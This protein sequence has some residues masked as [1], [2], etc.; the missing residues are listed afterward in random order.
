MDAA[1]A[2][3]NTVCN[4]F[5]NPKPEQVLD[6]ICT[7]FWLAMLDWQDDGVKIGVKDNKVN[8]YP[9][10]E[11]QANKRR[12]DGVGRGDI[13]YLLPALEKVRKFWG[14][15]KNSHI[16][17]VASK[18]NRMLDRLKYPYTPDKTIISCVGNYRRILQDVLDGKGGQPLTE[19]EKLKKQLCEGTLAEARGLLDKRRMKSL[20]TLIDENQDIYLAYLFQQAQPSR[21][22]SSYPS[23]S[24]PRV[25]PMAPPAA[26]SST[27]S[28]NSSSPQ[29]SVSS[30][31]A[32]SDIANQLHP[33]TSPPRTDRVWAQHDA[34]GNVVG[35]H[36][37]PPGDDA[38]F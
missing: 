11:D 8:Y 29:S 15:D 9:P 22:T 1:R 4:S 14:S 31:Y 34:D 23:R 37:H 36:N 12:A 35:Y 28:V 10:G 20:E 19:D 21:M 30:S 5:S 38:E 7:L 13:G 2:V 26:T 18:A 16:L 24:L 32:L 17:E 27:G 25:I 6:P 33:G 3:Y